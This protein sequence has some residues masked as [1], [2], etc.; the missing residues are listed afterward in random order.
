MRT[1]KIFPVILA[2]TISLLGCAQVPK[3][4]QEQLPTLQ[5][6]Q[7]RWKVEKERLS[8]QLQLAVK[9][10]DE[11]KKAVADFNNRT[12]SMS[13][14]IGELQG[15]LQTTQSNANKVALQRD[16]AMTQMAD[17]KEEIAALKTELGEIWKIANELNNQ[18]RSLEQLSVAETPPSPRR[19]SRQNGRN[20]RCRQKLPPRW[21]R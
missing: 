21:R 9:S 7:V 10:A 18:K 12:Q 16:A 6:E 13:Q 5:S 2:A 3:Q 14:Q 4:A 1:P 8:Q 20:E 15:Q 19:T 17:L 11:A